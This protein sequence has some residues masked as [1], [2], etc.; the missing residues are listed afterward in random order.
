M[1]SANLFGLP[2]GMALLQKFLARPTLNPLKGGQN[3]KFWRF[4]ADDITRKKSLI[5]G[6]RIF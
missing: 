3:L 1:V 6:M 4:L 5:L 2:L